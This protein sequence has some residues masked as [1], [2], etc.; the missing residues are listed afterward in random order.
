MGTQGYLILFLLALANSVTSERFQPLLSADTCVEGEVQDCDCPTSLFRNGFPPGFTFGIGSSSYQ[1]EGA[2]AIDGKGPSIWDTFTADYPEKIADHSNGSVADDSY[3]RY[4]EDVKLLKEMGVDAYRFSISWSRILPSGN[5][6][7]HGVNQK[8]VEY[9]NNLINELLAYNI[10][11]F[12]SLFHWD[13][14]QALEDAYGGF[15]SLNIK[16]DF[17]TYANVCFSEFG[18]RVKHWVTLNEP[19][20]FSNYGYGEG[21]LAPGRCSSWLESNNCTS[22]N[23]GEEPYNVTH[24]QLISHA[25]AVQLYREKYQKVQ[26]GKIGITL[27]TRWMV[28]LSDSDTDIEAAFRTLNFS[29]GWFLDPLTFGDYPKCMKD[30]VQGRLPNFTEEES[31]LLTKSYDFLGLNYYTGR[32]VV[33]ASSCSYVNN[34]YATDCY[35]NQTVSRDGVC[36]GPRYNSSWIYVYPRG[37]R[38]YLNY[39]HEIYKVSSIYITEN[40]IE[41]LNGD[42]RPIWEVLHDTDRIK[43][44]SKHLCCIHQAIQD[45]VNVEGY[46]AWSLLDNFEWSAGYT[47]RYGFYYVDYENNLARYPKLSSKWY[48]SV[49][50]KGEQHPQQLIFDE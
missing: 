42:G 22:G 15:M 45:G 44:H 6:S 17:V 8:G 48:K 19:W 31:K 29:L 33:D 2:V 20:S 3:D 39:V 26:K 41:E 14:P 43:Y 27:V 24:N 32:Y 47:S 23:S 49:L 16:D 38:D 25:Y 12:V 34:S 5:L 50:E 13:L 46:F 21:Q 30:H 36:I 40:G 28:P 7:G 18:D 9:Y 35:A 4:K 11:P 10:T 37:I 1:F